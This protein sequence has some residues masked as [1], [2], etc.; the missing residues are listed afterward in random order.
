VILKRADR[1]VAVESRDEAAPSKLA[2]QV[3]PAAT[4]HLYRNHPS[5]IIWSMANEVEFTGASVNQKTKDLLAK[6]ITAT[7]QADPTRP[8]GLGGTW[9]DYV[10]RHSRTSAIFQGYSQLG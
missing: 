9:A 6:M 3:H 1:L 7:H 5:V 10:A 4:H 2:A 8:A